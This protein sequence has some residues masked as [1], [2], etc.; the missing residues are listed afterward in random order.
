MND[1]AHIAVLKGYKIMT[2]PQ[3][4]TEIKDDSKF[5]SNECVNKSL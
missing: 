4:K 2:C 5:C 3:C 1:F